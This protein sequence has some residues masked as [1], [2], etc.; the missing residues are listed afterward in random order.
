ML[1]IELFSRFMAEGG[2]L[3]IAGDEGQ[4]IYPR[5]FTWKELD[6]K[7]SPYSLSLSINKRNPVEIRRFA[8]RLEGDSPVLSGTAPDAWGIVRV[9]REPKENTVA[10][11]RELAGHSDETT[12]VVATEARVWEDLLKNAGITTQT[13]KDY[14]V[15]GETI[16]MSNGGVRPG[17]YCFSQFRVKGLEFDNV[18]IDYA[19]EIDG[20][21][22][23]RE[24][25]IR[26]MQFTRARKTLL[27]RY[28]GEAPRLLKKYYPDY[29]PQP[30]A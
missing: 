9:R 21:D 15:S 6:S 1:H 11:V 3:L 25:R 8:E 18:I 29:L 23:R 20:Q 26:Y 17:V 22:E 4:R 10:Y 16:R 14:G 27:V 30:P 28:D 24:R 7:L 5:D 19:G 13:S 2:H 12:V